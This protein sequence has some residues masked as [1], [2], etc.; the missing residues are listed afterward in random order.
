MTSSYRN[1]RP[2]PRRRLAVVG[3]LLTCLATMALITA[4][5][6]AKP[7]TGGAQQTPS[8]QKDVDALVA[9]G[10]PGTILLVRDGSHTVRLAGGLADVALKRA[11]GPD[12]HFKIASLTKTYTAV[13]QHLPGVVPN[14]NRITIRQLLNHRSG[15]F[16]FEGDP[17][18]LKPYLAGKFGHYCRAS[19]FVWP[20]RTSHCL[21]QAAAGRTRTRITSSPS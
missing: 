4:T 5:A 19:S 8:L 13:Q 21:R 3:V 15:V 11:M 1:P 2:M 7:T 10:A 9:A 16:D 14:G 12:D 18:Y 20:Y 17:R 6:M